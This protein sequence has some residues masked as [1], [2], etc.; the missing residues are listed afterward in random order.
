MKINALIFGTG[1]LFFK[2]KVEINNHYNILSFIDND[3][4]KKGGFIDGIII[5]SPDEIPSLEYDVIVISSSYE[6]EIYDQL[7]QLGVPK[8]KIIFLRTILGVEYGRVSSNINTGSLFYNSTGLHGENLSIVILSYNRV[9][10]TIRLL[11]SLSN[12]IPLFKG[13]IVIFDNGSNSNELDILKKFIASFKFI[14]IVV[15]NNENY[16]VAK[17][18]NNAINVVTKDWIFFIDNDIYL[19][20]N[21]LIAIHETISKFNT[22]YINLPLLNKDSMTVYSFGGNVTTS[23]GYVEIS[24]FIPEGFPKCL[25]DHCITTEVIFGSFLSGGTAVYHRESFISEGGFDEDLFIG[26]EDVVFSIS[27][28]K[29]GVRIANIPSFHMIHDHARESDHDYNKIRYDKKTIKESAQKIYDKYGFKLYSSNVWQWL[30][31]RCK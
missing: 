12:H 18:R 7:Q 17:G 2:N 26:F 20:S 6:G 5:H 1:S 27:L 11:S 16:G 28:M 3:P 22:P 31:D 10:M 21:P 23:D 25:V 15:E 29:K 8:R 9:D 14:C 4:K 13:E 24:P 19:I 30:D